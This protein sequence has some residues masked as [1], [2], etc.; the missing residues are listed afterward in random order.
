MKKQLLFVAFIIATGFGPS[1]IN[2]EVE[3][4]PPVDPALTCT[5]G[6]SGCPF[7]CDKNGVCRAPGAIVCGTLGTPNCPFKC[8]GVVGVCELP[9]DRPPDPVPSFEDIP[10]P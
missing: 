1:Q 10:L 6:T 9:A 4:P 3:F 5:P 7:T 8:I 2:A